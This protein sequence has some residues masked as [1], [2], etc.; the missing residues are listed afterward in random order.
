MTELERRIEKL[1]QMQHR[2]MRMLEDIAHPNE[3]RLYNVDDAAELLSVR[4]ATLREWLRAGKVKAIKLGSAWKI[5]DTELRRLIN[6]NK[7]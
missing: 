7:K 1:E 3:G 6:D 4:P 2:V 5:S